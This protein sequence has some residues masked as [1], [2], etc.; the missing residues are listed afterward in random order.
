MA[1]T[2][3]AFEIQ[4]QRPPARGPLILPQGRVR[5]VAPLVGGI[6]L[7]LEQQRQIDAAWSGP[8]QK[9]SP[10]QA[11]LVESHA[12]Y[13]GQTA[14]KSLSDWHEVLHTGQLA[15]LNGAFA[16]AWQSGPENLLLLRDPMGER[17]L[18]YAPCGQGL[19]FASSLELLIQSGLIR[20]EL[21]LEALTRYL[22]YA[23]LPGHET[24]IQGVYELLPGEKLSWQ[25]GLIET[26]NYWDL[27]PAEMDL[28]PE[29]A[30]QGL[31]E[32]IEM[33]VEKRLPAQEAVCA[34]LSGG[35]D[36]SLVVALLARL[37]LRPVHTWSVSFGKAYRNELPFSQ[38]VAEAYQTRHQVLEV[39]PRTVLYFLDETLALLGNPI[40]DPLTVPNA[41]LF[42]AASEVGPVLFNGEGG[43]PLFGGPKN[44]PMLLALLY[45]SEDADPVH[46][47]VQTYLQSYRKLYNDL[48]QLLNAATQ[49]A[50]PP[51]QLA[52]DLLPWFEAGAGKSLV[53]TLM[54]VNTRLKGAHH[55]LYK[56][57]ALS[58]GLG[59]LPASPLFDSDVAQWA[60]RV[61]PQ[62]KLMGS[63]EKYI[64]KQAVSDLLPEQV[65][66]RPKSGMQVPVELWFRP[67]GPLHREAKKRLKNLARYPWFNP[68]YLN[69][70]MAW[71]LGGYLP[72]HGLKVWILL[73]LE[74]WLRHYLGPP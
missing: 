29:T 37:S 24:L 63:E 70:L 72:R 64:L 32:A 17:T 33:A 38:A 43:D 52:A 28:D 16:L 48:P 74:A 60:F 30:R 47:T 57:N 49:A 71:E 44:I 62:L 50:L 2:A 58:R 31:R 15:T 55:I 18:F 7:S 42:R 73:S 21:N 66:K 68:V 35:I 3:A 61:P 65:L 23:Y 26:K 41:L 46:S 12:A 6:G 4:T 25:A 27:P 39:H 14:L 13:S 19:I 40:G 59:M 10:E 20:R 9:L 5:K 67:G 1:K 54:T 53:Q 8:V 36:S 22:S 34:S 69:Q 51:G 56:V 11:L 45:A